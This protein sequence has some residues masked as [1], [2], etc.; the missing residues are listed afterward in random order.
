MPGY[1]STGQ[2]VLVSPYDTTFGSPGASDDKSS[3]AAMVE[4]ARALGAKPLRNDIVMIFTDGEEPGL[5]GASS[6]VAEHANSGQGGGPVLNWEATG[7]A[8]PAVLFETSAGNAELIKEFGTA[9][10][11]PIGDSALAALYQAGNQ[12]TDFMVFKNAGFVG[13]NFALMDGTAAYHNSVDTAARLDRAGLQHMGPNMLR[14]TRELADRDLASLRSSDDAVFF[15]IFRQLITLSELAGLAA[16]WSGDC[17][18]GGFGCAGATSERSDHSWDTGRG[19]SSAVADHHGA[20][21]RDR[22]VAAADH[23]P[24]GICDAAYG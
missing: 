15:T 12:N 7:N 24:A 16:G 14:P 18:H 1:D 23:G 3:V 4:T 13:L 21:G 10:E 19:R 8:G 20:A 5:L 9:A 17:D 11:L 22:P 2:V 6:Y